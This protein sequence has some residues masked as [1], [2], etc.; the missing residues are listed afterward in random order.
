MCYPSLLRCCGFPLRVFLLT[1]F[2]LPF[3]IF[4]WN[5]THSVPQTIP[6]MS[7]SDGHVSI[8]VVIP[9]YNR[10]SLVGTA[11]DSV[12]AQSHQ[13]AEVIVVDDGSTDNTEAEVAR[14]AGKVRYVRQANA[15]ASE[16]RNRGVASTT[17]EWVAFLDSDDFWMPSHLEAMERAMTE[18]RGGAAMYFSDMRMEEQEGGGSLWEHCGFR[19]SGDFQMIADGAEWVMMDRQPMMLQTGV[20]HR[21]AYRDVGGLWN[22]LRTRHDTHFFLRLGVGRPLC[23]VAGIGAC[24][25]SS[26]RPGNRLMSASGPESR[27]YWEESIAMYDDILSNCTGLSESHKKVIRGRV[28]HVHWRLGRMAWAGRHPGSCLAST[29]RAL[30]ASPEITLGIIKRWIFR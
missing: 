8:A 6:L 16:A 26:D 11:I 18:T 21:S 28:A 14:F 25:T 3:R 2:D 20:V 22:R 19:I 12:L 15:G 9:T 5:I 13:A 4:C 7:S 1:F 30:A 27:A 29:G 10:G 23:A 24:Q 17:A